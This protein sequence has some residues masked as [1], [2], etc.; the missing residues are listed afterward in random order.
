MGNVGVFEPD[1]VGF[2]ICASCGA[3]IRANREWCL[4]CH[5]PLV[6][7]KKPEI[8]L[9]S[10]IHSLGGGTFIFAL[11]GAVTIGVTAYLTIESKANQVDVSVRRPAPASAATTA[12][13]HPATS[14][15][16]VRFVDTPGRGAA[17]FQDADLA[18]TRAQFEDAV[19]QDPRDAEAQNNLGLILERLKLYDAAV[20][21]FSDAA[22]ID[23]HN[24]VYHFNLAHA[25]S[26]Q[27]RWR[28]AATE[29]A[30][31]VELTPTNYAARYNLG[32]ALHFSSN[33]PEAI[34]AYKRAID[35]AP[36]D[37]AP[38][39][40]LAVSLESSGDAAGALNEY[41]QYLEMAPT[42]TNAIAVKAHIQA[43][44]HTS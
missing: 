19:R 24:W 34:K 4:R 9:P 7:W 27:Q 8:P 11:V 23:G 37:P 10:W 33:E 22:A 18:E 16:P 6:A 38:H 25:S 31:V 17:D 13:V 29:Y 5:E 2:V 1:E 26:L 14:V 30:A 43:L 28:R 41:R 20:K 3:R 21:C 12:A 39:L 40:S 36:D 35:M 32:V 44:S 42:A 15:E